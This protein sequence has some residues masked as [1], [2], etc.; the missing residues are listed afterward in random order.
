MI[1]DTA[2]HCWCRVSSNPPRIH[3]KSVK[4]RGTDFMSELRFC[5]TVYIDIDQL[6]PGDTTTHTFVVPDWPYCTTRYFYFWGS[7]D[8]VTCVST[9]PPFHYHNAYSYVPP[10]ETNDQYVTPPQNVWLS[11]YWSARGQLFSPD[12]DYTARRISLYLATSFASQRQGPYIVKL[13]LVGGNCGEEEILWSQV[14]YSTDLPPDFVSEY[15][16]WDDINIPLTSGV[17]YR[18]V[19]YATPGWK[20]WNGSQWIFNENVQTIYAVFSNVTPRYPRGNIVYN[21]NIRDSVGP[22]LI[23]EP[24]NQLFIVWE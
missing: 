23:S 8:S 9:S 22:W 24:N 19:F 17:Q 14:G 1:T 20:Y 5:F 15:T 16:H 4:R 2:S 21:C 3:K 11:Y 7:V 12:H 10:V 18:I 6:E 13:C